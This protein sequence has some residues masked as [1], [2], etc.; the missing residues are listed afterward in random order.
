MFAQ[1]GWDGEVTSDVAES[2]VPFRPAGI[3]L[4]GVGCDRA[5]R[6]LLLNLEI[7]VVEMGERSHPVDMLVQMS[8]F[9]AGR[10]MGQH[11]GEQEFGRIAFCGHT[12][13]H[14]AERLRGFR[15]GLAAFGQEPKL[16]LPIEG[17]QTFEDGVA[18]LGHILAD[19]P[20]CDAVFYGSDVLAFGALMEARKRAIAVPQDL[21]IAGYGDLDF[22]RHVEPALTTINIASYDTG[23]LAG[24]MLLARL[25]QQALEHTIA[26]LP[27]R[28][29]ARASTARRMPSA[30][31][32]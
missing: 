10:L 7:P 8:S 15:N 30:G 9:E 5:T 11:F 12:L 25:D 29:E 4:T 28:L 27:V 18:S 1:T 32:E 13:G 26:Q 17:T 23:R 31:A 20:G 3:V 21:A 16:V 2:V 19:L 22:S 14:G 6:K 24:E